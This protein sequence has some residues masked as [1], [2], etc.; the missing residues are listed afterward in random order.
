MC[1][2]VYSKS[3]DINQPSRFGLSE[4]ASADVNMFD[5]K[6]NRR[7][8]RFKSSFCSCTQ[9]DSIDFYTERLSSALIELNQAKAV[10]DGEGEVQMSYTLFI[11]HI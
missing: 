5:G 6:S 2:N 3:A 8:S 1:G 4:A 10:I 11:E 9:V 7:R